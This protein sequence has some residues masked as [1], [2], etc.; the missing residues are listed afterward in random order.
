MYFVQSECG[1]IEVRAFIRLIELQCF[2]LWNKRAMD[3][4]ALLGR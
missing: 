3:S 1:L 2:E 4:S